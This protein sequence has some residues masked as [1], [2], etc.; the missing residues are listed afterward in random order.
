MLAVFRFRVAPAQRPSLLEAARAALRVLSDRPGFVGARLA[1]SAD[2]PHDWLLVTEWMGMGPWRRAL[3]DYDVRVQVIPWLAGA[4]V[5]Q[6]AFEVLIAADP[7]GQV[8]EH[9]PDVAEELP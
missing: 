3:S 8:T 1:R 7:G 5:E 6:G 4:G 2:D 9:S